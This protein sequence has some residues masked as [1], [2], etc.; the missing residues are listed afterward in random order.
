MK[1]ASCSAELS[2]S[3]RFC[4]SCGAPTSSADVPTRLTGSPG[5]AS[6]GAGAAPILAP[7]G[8]VVSTGSVPVGG[9]APGMVLAERYRIIGLLGR[10]G[11]GEVYRADDLKLGQPVALKFLP[12]ALADDP[13]RRERFYAEVRIARQVSHPNIC[14]VYDIG[15]IA[16]SSTRAGG[17]GSDR[18]AQGRHF[19]T[20]EYVDGEDLASLLTRIG[21]LPGDK[22]IDVA[23]QLC[24]GLA[25]AHD[26]GVLH[27]DLKPANVMI[28]GRGRVRITDFGIAV[29]A[30]EDA[31]AL[32]VAGT[33]A[34]MAPEQFAGQGTSVRSDIYALGLLFYE[35]YTGRRAFDAKTLAELRA[36]KET[37]T[38]TAASEI[39][40][41]IDP[42]V[43]RVILRCLE[44]DPRHRPA[45]VAQVA[46]A[47]PGG[48]PLAAAIAAGET[49]SP[50]MVAASGSREGL[51]PRV[52]WSCLV[53][54]I[55][56]IGVAA[57]LGSQAQLIQRAAP[58]KSPEVLAERA[59]EILG[60]IGN[61]ATP[62]DS[63]YGVSVDPD[64]LR[65][66][67]SHDRSP[68]RWNRLA[69]FAM[70]FWYRQSPRALEQVLFFPSAGIPAVGPS[71][72]PR[73][74]SG[75]SIVW[76]DGRGRLLYL[77][78][79]PPQLDESS[80]TV[81]APDWPLL[82]QQAGLDPAKWTAVQPHWTPLLY[83]DTRT[84]WTGV[85]PERPDVPMRIEAAAYRGKPVYWDLI[86]PWTRPGRMVA[87]IPSPGE[88]ATVILLSALLATLMVGGAFF[89]RRNLRMGRGDRRGAVRLASLTFVLM[90]IAW[91]F[92][93][94]H[95]PTFW[96]VGLF[97]RCLSFALFVSGLLWLLYISLEPFVRRRWPG[98]LISWSR[99]LAGKFRDPLVGRDV[100]VGCVLGVVTVL[101]NYGTY[102]VAAWMGVPQDQPIVGPPA[103]F[104]GGRMIAAVAALWIVQ[105]LFFAL[106][107]LFILFLLR[108]LLRSEWAAA[109]LLIVILAAGDILPSD[110]P[111]LTG[112]GSVL[113]YAA[114]LFVLTRVG[115]LALVAGFAVVA[116]LQSF[117]VTTHLSTWYSGIGMVGVLLILGVTA[118]GFYTSLGG[119]P[120]FGRLSLED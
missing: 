105:P 48:D 89:A 21:R 3:H 109:V 118:Y 65:Y 43:E 12:K 55:L 102:L 32:E 74:V 58:D 47:L 106:A 80:G 103:L 107:W 98:S 1:C 67:R 117:P 86:G 79:V 71:D 39:T 50:E 113:A 77:E 31:A 104:V 30:G 33:P 95:V 16:G 60:T 11:M 88:R 85:L 111:V 15:E 59:R 7:V 4:P 81:G 101:L 70:P 35:V 19:L 112:L 69:G 49:P 5:V 14:R 13:V 92:G 40:R 90:A 56:G 63:A 54:V 38:P 17:D 66:L 20:M 62:T 75:E 26:K 2:S 73:Q 9:F 93:A 34:Y 119:Q 114:F 42:I 36:Q 116:I 91:L 100:L 22:A 84:A 61:T 46:A 96:E 72:P 6:A 120:L 28:D 24:A 76:L 44:K 37:A 68:S 41:D 108:T 52:A 8:R 82:F 23:R 110:S 97:I 27:R 18:S 10:G 87:Y 94:S 45:S 99:L 29:V 83:A 51:R 53:F 57:V 78:V 64:Y 25:A 115:L